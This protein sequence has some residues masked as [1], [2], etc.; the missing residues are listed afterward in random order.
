MLKANPSRTFRN[1]VFYPLR[2]FNDHDSIA[3]ADGVRKADRPRFAN[4][5]QPV[6]IHVDEMTVRRGAPAEPIPLNEH[7]GRALGPLA[8]AESTR[9]P[10]DERGLAA[11]ELS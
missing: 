9:Q 6:R 1:K 3:I 2:P 5:P 8:D 10:L 11:T 7:K 4:A